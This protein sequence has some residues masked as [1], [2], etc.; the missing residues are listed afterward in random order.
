MEQMNRGADAVKRPSF[1]IAET[2]VIIAIVAVDC[3]VLRVTPAN[4]TLIYVIVGGAPVQS[5]LVTG[6]IT[7]FRRR[8]QMEKPNPF[9]IGFEVVGWIG[10]L[11]YVAFC[12]QAPESIDQHVFHVLGPLLDASGFQRFSSPD[13]IWRLTLIMSL[14]S[15]PQLAAALLAGWIIKRCSK[16]A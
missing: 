1:S 16:Q 9:L 7:M 15:A 11:I 10:L 5:A 13:M 6:L 8:G 14:V 2:M 4:L 12:F 3:L